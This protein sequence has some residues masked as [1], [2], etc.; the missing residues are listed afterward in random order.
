MGEWKRENRNEYL[1]ALK[2]YRETKAL[3]PMIRLFTKE[4]FFYSEKCRYI[5]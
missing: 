5:M 4:L 1:E 2:A 3:K